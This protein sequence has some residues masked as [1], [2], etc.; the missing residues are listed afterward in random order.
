MNE[1]LEIRK[2]R[3]D[4]CSNQIQATDK[5]KLRSKCQSLKNESLKIQTDYLQ[6]S[7]E[8]IGNKLFKGQ[9]LFTAILS[10]YLLKYVECCQN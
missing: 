3:L 6:N 4:Q 9:G 7:Q 5:E 8:L 2:T 1:L 10:T